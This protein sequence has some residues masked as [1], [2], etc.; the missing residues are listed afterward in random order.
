[1]R[2]SPSTDV[3]RYGILLGSG[4]RLR[5]AL[6]DG[7]VNGSAADVAGIKPADRVVSVDGLLTQDN[8]AFVR[9]LSN[10]KQGTVASLGVVRGESFVIKGM[11][12]TTELKS[13]DPALGQELHA[14]KQQQSADGE[15]MEAETGVLEGLGSVL[16]GLISGAGKG[17]AG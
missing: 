15:S 4:S 5:G 9:Q 1:M 17:G 11:K 3:Q 2:L 10:L 16:G 8:T 13:Q 14:S 7:V 12:L 6:V